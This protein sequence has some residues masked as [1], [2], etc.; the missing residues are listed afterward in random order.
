[1]KS[2]DARRVKTL[3]EEYGAAFAERFLASM[4]AP[5]KPTA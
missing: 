1:V 5:A 3:V 2:E 4:P